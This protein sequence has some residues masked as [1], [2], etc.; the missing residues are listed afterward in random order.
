[1]ESE[2]KDNNLDISAGP[3]ESTYFEKV[4]VNNAK[5]FNSIC[6]GDPC[7]GSFNEEIILSDQDISNY[8]IVVNDGLISAI[9]LTTRIVNLERRSEFAHA[10]L[11]KYNALFSE[12]KNQPNFS[13]WT[14]LDKNRRPIEVL[15]ITDDDLLTVNVSISYRSQI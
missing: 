2:T 4:F 9:K 14:D 1:M 12:N 10:I 13:S 15:L 6:L 7:K 8:N 5:F 3:K 11:N